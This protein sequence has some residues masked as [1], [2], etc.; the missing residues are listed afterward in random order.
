MPALTGRN[1]PASNC[2]PEDAKAGFS[3]A[4]QGCY[5]ALL[6]AS[7]LG[8]GGEVGPLLNA[9]LRQFSG[10]DTPAGDSD[11]RTIAQSSDFDRRS[12]KPIYS[13]YIADNTRQPTP[14]SCCH[15]L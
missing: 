4:V 7:K 10:L 2:A 12:D 9:V 14:P 11:V 1:L 6:P 3:L 15:G 5:A 8:P 13:E